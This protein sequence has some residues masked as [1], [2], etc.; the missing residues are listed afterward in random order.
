[1]KT[2]LRS[3]VGRIRSINEDRAVIRNDINGITIALLAD[4]MGGHQAGDIASQTAMEV[5][6]RELSHLQPTMTAVEWEVAIAHAI[7]RANSE[8]YS[9][10]LS[11]PQLSGMGTTII[12]ALTCA[13]RLTVANIGDSRVYL[14]HNEEL[15]QLTEDHSLVNELLKNGQI[16]ATEAATHPRRNML[17]RALG[18]EM[19]VEADIKHVDWNPGD[20][21]L[22]C[23][24]GL[25]NMMSE[26]AIVHTLQQQESLD[27]KADQLIEKALE[28]GGDDNVTVVLIEHAQEETDRGE[29]E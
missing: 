26:T 28:A 6:S 3:D 29:S 18:T 17:T 9:Q 21:L 23:S 2:A 4:G 5:V 20:V 7:E 27:W 16:S 12:V 25:T 15:K 24:D 8:I 19:R 14:L 11:N 10:S 22:L 13:G 1:M